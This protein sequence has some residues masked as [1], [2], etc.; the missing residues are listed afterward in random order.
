MKTLTRKEVI[1]FYSRAFPW[2]S[3]GTEDSRYVIPTRKWLEEDFARFFEDYKFSRNL[4][5]A[6]QNFDC[7]DFARLYQSEAVI[8]HQASSPNSGTSL[9]VGVLRYQKDNAYAHQA[10]ASIVWDE[11]SNQLIML[12]VEPQSSLT[13]KPTDEEIRSATSVNL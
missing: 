2:A 4:T 9:T 3:I 6:N 1:D 11:E 10:N 12:C 5:Y 13:F 8:A 7:E